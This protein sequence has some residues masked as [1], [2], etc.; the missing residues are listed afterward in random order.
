MGA[1]VGCELVPN[2]DPATSLDQRRML[3]RVKLVFMGNLASVDR[4]REHRVNVSARER[5]AATLGAIRGCAA[6]RPK[7]ETVGLLLDPAHA[8]EVTI[9][10]EDAAHRLSL[11]RV[12]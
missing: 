5:F 10:C 4:V 3:A 7:R 1:R 2:R 8:A 6:F 9:E 12:D 11:G